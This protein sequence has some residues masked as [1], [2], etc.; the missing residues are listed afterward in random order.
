[1]DMKHCDQFGAII[2]ILQWIATPEPAVDHLLQHFHRE[3]HD[4]FVLGHELEG[5]DVGPQ[6]KAMIIDRC[7]Q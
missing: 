6:G 2:I 4:E 5:G 3:P 1:M 7:I